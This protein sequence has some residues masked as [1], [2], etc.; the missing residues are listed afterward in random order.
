MEGGTNEGGETVRSTSVNSPGAKPNSIIHGGT[1]PPTPTGAQPPAHLFR[2]RAITSEVMGGGCVVS[3]PA[4]EHISP[5]L[6]SS[7]SDCAISA[8]L[9]AL[10]P[11]QKAISVSH[12]MACFHQ[13]FAKPMGEK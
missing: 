7:V 10:T 3:P 2:A 4:L 12:S 6:I 13:H 11:N 8:G 9:C 1:N 5:V